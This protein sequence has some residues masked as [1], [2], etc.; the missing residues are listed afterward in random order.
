VAQVRRGLDAI[1]TSD[2]ADEP[3]SGGTALIDACYTAMAL[4]DAD[5]GR[6]LLI[7]FT[8]GIDTASWLT[9]ERV[10]PAARRSNV[11]AYAVSTADLPG[12]SFLERLS[13]A[14]GGEAIEIAS[15]AELRTTFLRI[16]AE[17][18]QR[19]LVSY[20][21]AG[22]TGESWHPLVVRVKGRRVDIKTRAGYFR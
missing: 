19:Y 2:A 13:D 10:L 20:S 1:G 7:A 22:V 9:A 11:V 3:S 12:G 14:T 17:F 6:T 21:P 5:A 16:I 18:R 4:A 15:T 8:D